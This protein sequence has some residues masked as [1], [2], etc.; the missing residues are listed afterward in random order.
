M[1]LASE[2]PLAKSSAFGGIAQIVILALVL[3]VIIRAFLFQPY[4]IPS[5][6]M[7]STLL[8]GDYVFVSKFSYGYSRYALPFDLAFF[9][10]RLFE[11][12][13]ERGDVA[14][15]RL[16]K[17]NSIDLIKRVIGLPGDRVQM[18]EGVVYINGEAVRRQR[19]SDFITK[20]EFGADRRVA[21]YRETLPSGISYDTLDLDPVSFVDNTPVYVVPEGHYFVLGDNRDNSQDSRTEGAVGFIPFENFIGRAEYVFFSLNEGEPAWAFWRWPWTVR[22]ERLFTRL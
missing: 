10:G 1:S 2:K 6:S 17:D 15:F 11:H 7:E 5:S 20:N 22:A 13:P 12:R 16:P 3:A 9:G 19:I 21:R 14:V 18:R 8:A 4:R